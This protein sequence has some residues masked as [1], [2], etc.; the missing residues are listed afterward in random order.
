VR[1]IDDRVAQ[2]LTALGTF[3][4]W[5]NYLLVTTVAA[6]GWVAIPNHAP[7]GPL[8]YQVVVACLGLSVLFG[9]LTL[10]MI[11]HVATGISPQTQSFYKVRVW[12]KLFWLVGPVLPWRLMFVCAP[13]HALFIV[14]ILVFTVASIAS[15]GPALHAGMQMAP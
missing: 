12:I 4:D 8:A 11:P 5:S 9:I 7:L 13:Q 2:H 1:T 3:K 10:A 6:L 14:G 15:G